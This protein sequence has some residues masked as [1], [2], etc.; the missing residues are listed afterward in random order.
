M[1]VGSGNV[2]VREDF[3]EEE[4]TDQDLD[5]RGR[6]IGSKEE[7]WKWCTG[8]AGG[9][10]LTVQRLGARAHIPPGCHTSR[11]HASRQ[12]LFRSSS[13][14]AQVVAYFPGVTWTLCI[15]SPS[16]L[17]GGHPQPPASHLHL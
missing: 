7:G 6:K 4:S 1:R 3:L 8:R 17:L 5:K 16:A 10:I 14:K 15:N 13:G 11:L 12:P 2:S 9:E